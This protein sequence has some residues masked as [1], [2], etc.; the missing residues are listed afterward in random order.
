MLRT[1]V[2]DSIYWIITGC[3][4]KKNKKFTQYNDFSAF[5]HIEDNKTSLWCIII[6]I[7]LCFGDIIQYNEYGN[8]GLK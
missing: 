2:T 8:E 4:R 3:S 5:A 6:G 7:L 1:C